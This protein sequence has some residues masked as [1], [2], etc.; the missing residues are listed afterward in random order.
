MTGGRARLVTPSEMSHRTLL[1]LADLPEGL[2]DRVV[3]ALRQAEP[4]AVGVLVTGSYAGGRATSQSDLD[5]TVLTA[6]RPLGHYRTWFEP[7]PGLPLHVSAGA[8][9]LTDWVEEGHTAADWALGLPTEEVAV[10]AWATDAARAVLGEP[11]LRRR[12]PAPPE[13]ED[14]LECATKAKR[15]VAAGDPLG[16]RWHAHNLGRYAPRL[17]RPLNPEQR[18]TSTRHAL[19]AALEMPVVPPGYREDL[20]LC[21]G[22]QSA[23]DEE[24]ATAAVRLATAILAFLRERMPDVDRQPDLPRYLADGTLERHLK[25]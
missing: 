1:T 21:L 13:L 16:A 12:P 18:V 17:L 23:G 15:A 19:R 25:G 5:V 9:S 7:R 3:A 24:V 14:F 8:A 11:P 4:A 22:L 2:L 6:V 10:W 20:T